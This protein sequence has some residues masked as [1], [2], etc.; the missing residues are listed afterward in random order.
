MHIFRYLFIQKAE[1][2]LKFY[3]GYRNRILS[4]TFKTELDHLK[5]FSKTVKNESK[6]R[7]GDLGNYIYHLLL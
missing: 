2:S 7:F 3:K 6:F 4:L 1:N 5:T